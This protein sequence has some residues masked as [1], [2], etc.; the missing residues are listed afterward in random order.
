MA[1]YTEFVIDQ[2]SDFVVS[3]SLKDVNGNPLSLFGYSLTG[4]FRKSFDSETVYSLNVYTS[5]ANSGNISVGLT[6]ANS[7]NVEPGKYAFDINAYTANTNLR[8]LEGVLTLT[9]SVI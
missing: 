7:C 6:G 2:D 8:I 1:T 3:V 5:N 4:K 9:P